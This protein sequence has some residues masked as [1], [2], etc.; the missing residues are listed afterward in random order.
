M[1]EMAEALTLPEHHEGCTH[2]TMTWRMVRQLACKMYL[3]KQSLEIS[4]F[5]FKALHGA[6]CLTCRQSKAWMQSCWP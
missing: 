2:V 1:K 5:F 3:P 6:L 4:N